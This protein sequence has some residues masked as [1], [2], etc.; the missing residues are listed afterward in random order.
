MNRK[1]RENMGLMCDHKQ[2]SWS[3]HFLVRSWQ[4]ILWN[5][6]VFSPQ[7]SNSALWFNS[8][9]LCRLRSGALIG[10]ELDRSY[11]RIYGPAGTT[12]LRHHI[13]TIDIDIGKCTSGP[14]LLATEFVTVSYWDQLDQILYIN[15][16]F[17]GWTLTFCNVKART[18]GKKPRTKNLIE[19]L[20]IARAIN[21]TYRSCRCLKLE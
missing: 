1:S 8:C 17:F 11:T 20:P 12:D 5:A 14:T 2:Y 16:T 18:N 21:T 19:T 7:P 10:P 15:F 13:D 6:V 4:A 9:I 3:R